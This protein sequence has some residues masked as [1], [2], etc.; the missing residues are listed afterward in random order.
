LGFGEIV[1]VIVLNLEFVGG[2]RGFSGIPEY[3]NI[4]WIYFF[5]LLTLIVIGRLTRS[6]KGKALLAIREDEIAAESIGIPTSRYKI[7]AFT[8]GA[9]FAGLGGGLFAHLLTY[10]HTNTFGFLKS[11]E[12]V[13]MVVLG[14]MGSLVGSI[15]A[16]TILTVLP[17]LLRAASEWRMVIY[18]LL[19][20][21]LML[22]RPQGLLGNSPK[23]WKLWKFW[24]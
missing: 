4:Y 24:K 5:V 8:L 20:I 16:A 14:G 19:L 12:F 18:S 11:I 9:F 23:F 2:A 7:I 15:L 22:W 1:R 17:E 3:S 6:T 10:L 21:I 13:V